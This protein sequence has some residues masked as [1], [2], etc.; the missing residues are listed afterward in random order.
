MP[1]QTLTFRALGRP[2]IHC[3]GTPPVRVLPAPRTAWKLRALPD[4]LLLSHATSFVCTPKCYLSLLIGECCRQFAAE[5]GQVQPPT[6][7]YYANIFVCEFPRYV[8]RLNLAVGESRNRCVSTMGF[9]CC[10]R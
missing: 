10:S 5:G 7:D 1:D 4:A 3:V 2:H 8:C 6:V 9:S